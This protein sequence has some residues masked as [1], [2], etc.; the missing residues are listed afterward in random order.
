[1]T[2]GNDFLYTKEK[3][4]SMKE[5]FC[6]LYFIKIENLSSRKW[7]DKSQTQRKYLQKTDPIKDCNPKY[8]KNS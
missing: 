2:L 4:G 7:E 8:T 5:I 3:T 6:K 1:M